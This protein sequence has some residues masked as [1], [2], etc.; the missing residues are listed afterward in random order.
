[1]ISKAKKNTQK[2]SVNDITLNEFYQ[3][4]INESIAAEDEKEKREKE[5]LLDKLEIYLKGKDLVLENC[6]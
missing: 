6:L 2:K 5:V 4:F 1:M 3:I